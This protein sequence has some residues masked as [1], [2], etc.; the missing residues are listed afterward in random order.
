ML[1]LYGALLAKMHLACPVLLQ[2][3]QKAIGSHIHET[4]LRVSCFV[5]HFR[6]R[7]LSNCMSPGDQVHVACKRKPANLLNCRPSHSLL[8]PT[9]WRAICG[10]GER[11]IRTPPSFLLQYGAPAASTSSRLEYT[12]VFGKYKYEKSHWNGRWYNFVADAE[13]PTIEQL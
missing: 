8:A 12:L 2:R 7:A 13:S 1:D 3:L 4:S 9:R 5:H 10:R 11:P 6:Y